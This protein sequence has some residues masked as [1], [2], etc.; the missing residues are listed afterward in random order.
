MFVYEV[1]HKQVFH[2]DPWPQPD[3]WHCLGRPFLVVI[4]YTKFLK[5]WH[6]SL[7]FFLG[8]GRGAWPQP[9]L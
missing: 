5:G 6:G 1:A 9:D 7:V 3:L 2:A 8:G 4:I